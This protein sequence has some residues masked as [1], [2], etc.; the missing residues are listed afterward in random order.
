MNRIAAIA[1]ASIVIFSGFAFDAP[2]K[3]EV[4]G[5]YHEDSVRIRLKQS[6]SDMLEG[7]WYYPDEHLSFVIE[8]LPTYKEG[9]NVV[10]RLV[11]V[12]ADDCAV[13]CGAVMGYMEKTAAKNQFKLWLYSGLVDDVPV[14][15]VECVA[16]VDDG[17]STVL[18]DRPDVKMRFSVNLARFLPS[19][20]GGVRI[21]PKVDK[22]SAKPGFRRLDSEEPDLMPVYF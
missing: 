14:Y 12:D 10:Y 8:R 13:D 22:P 7:L 15:P 19:I 17:F 18:I 2:K 20:F 9:K 4:L 21:Y 5:G 1:V 6:A 3:S 11:V 16:T